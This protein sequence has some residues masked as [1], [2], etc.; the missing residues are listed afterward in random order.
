VGTRIPLAV[1][2]AVIALVT[3]A[4]GDADGGDSTRAV[5]IEMRDIAFA[6]DAITVPAG[7]AIRLV[8]RNTGE[9]AHDAFIGD[10][11]AQSDH[12]AEMRAD[13]DVH[14]G[15]GDSGA[16]TVEPGETGSLTHTFE[17]GDRLLIGCHQPGHYTAGM[18]IADT[19]N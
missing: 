1:L 4:C 8:F 14:H 16:L 7:E 13:E 3:V 15:G 12:E 5:E 10:E 9:V 6:P 18:K 17:P 19:A 11:M 2:V